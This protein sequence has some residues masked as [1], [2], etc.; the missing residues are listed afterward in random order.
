[1]F[2]HDLT[3]KRGACNIPEEEDE[4]SILQE[5]VILSYFASSDLLLNKIL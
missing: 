3:S 5:N 2:P 4:L 1:M